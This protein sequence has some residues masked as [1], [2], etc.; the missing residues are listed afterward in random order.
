M[1]VHWKKSATK[2]ESWKSRFDLNNSI[3][4][5]EHLNSKES[6]Y[7]SIEK[8]I[9]K[10]QKIV[11]KKSRAVSLNINKRISVKLLATN[12]LKCSSKVHKSMKIHKET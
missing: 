12:Y 10:L 4:Q 7:T 1:K 5:T 3:L 8:N 9:T 2:C 6:Y 11:A